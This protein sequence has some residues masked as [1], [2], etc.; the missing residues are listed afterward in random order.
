M[1]ALVSASPMAAEERCT[2]GP[3]RQVEIKQENRCVCPREA[4]DQRELE[5]IY[6]D[7]YHG[8]LIPLFRRVDPST[9][10]LW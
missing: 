5:L 8:Q 9:P 2:P 10:R 7:T 4:P 3:A 6:R 1:G